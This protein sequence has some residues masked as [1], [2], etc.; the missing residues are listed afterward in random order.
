MDLVV[1]ALK[2]GPPAGRTVA[3][4][5]AHISKSHPDRV[6]A[7]NASATLSAAIA[8]ARKAKTPKI[9]VVK[10]GGPGVPSKY[11]PA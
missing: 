9:K 3:E 4:I 1:G 10:Q 8:Q 11:G 6:S 5:I 7:A 2:S